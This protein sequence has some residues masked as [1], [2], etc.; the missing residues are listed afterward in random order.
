MNI[1]SLYHDGEEVADEPTAFMAK[2]L[3]KQFADE[4]PQ[5]KPDFSGK[6]ISLFNK[7]T[8]R[9]VFTFVRDGRQ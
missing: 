3:K 1:V 6:T 8:V 4:N 9:G 2:L 5:A 7:K